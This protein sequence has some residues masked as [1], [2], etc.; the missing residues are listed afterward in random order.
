MN[1]RQ[2]VL[3]TATLLATTWTLIGACGV[4]AQE[5]A[6]GETHLLRYKFEPEEQ[7]R[8]DVEHKARIRT[9][10]AGSTQTAETNSGSVK[11][12]VVKEVDG[13]G[14]FLFEHSVEK[15]DMR[16]KLTGRSEL[17][18]SSESGED[19]PAGFESVATNVGVPLSRIKLSPLGKILGREELRPSQSQNNGFITI[20]LPEEAAAVG[21]VWLHPD[22]IQVSLPDG[23]IKHIEVRQRFKLL[24]VTGGV[25]KISV[26]TQVLTPV[27]DPQVKAQIVQQQQAGHVEFDIAAGRVIRQQMD[28]DETVIGFQGEASSLHYVTRFTEELAGD[29]AKTANKAAGPAAPP[30]LK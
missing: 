9:T 16:Q 28:L 18:Y 12:W 6:S 25:A 2:N 22:K 30:G 23:R 17:H 5:P 10:V 19:P 13:D 26:E 8:W 15:V 11:L 29:P 7:I 24:G 4:F 14:N 27:N 20:P 3:L 21:H 1:L